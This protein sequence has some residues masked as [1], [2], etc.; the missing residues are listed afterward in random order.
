MLENHMKQPPKESGE[1]D[2]IQEDLEKR[3]V[4]AQNKLFE[5]I[6]EMKDCIGEAVRVYKYCL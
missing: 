1:K 4:Y 5:C 3:C 6:K 2:K